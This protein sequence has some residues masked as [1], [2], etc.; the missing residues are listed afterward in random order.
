MPSRD[1]KESLT[2]EFVTHTAKAILIDIDGQK[3]WFP[4]SQVDVHDDP[5]EL[6]PGDEITILVPVWL[7][8]KRGL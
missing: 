1:D 6:E 2:G 7:L 8:R 5:E 3:E 4:L